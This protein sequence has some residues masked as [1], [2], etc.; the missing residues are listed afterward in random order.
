[1]KKMMRQ[2]SIS[3]K[4]WTIMRATMRKEM[5]YRANSANPRLLRENFG[6]KM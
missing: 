1:M 5:M 6:T 4:T 2:E 3:G